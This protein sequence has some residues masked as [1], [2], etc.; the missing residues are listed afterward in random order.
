MRA[1]ELAYIERQLD[2][3]EDKPEQESPRLHLAD[4]VHDP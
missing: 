4:A 2:K 3:T 1:A